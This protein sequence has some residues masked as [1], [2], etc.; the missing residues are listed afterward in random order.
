[1]TGQEAVF[2]LEAL[3]PPGGLYSS[4][5]HASPKNRDPAIA[6]VDTRSIAGIPPH[7]RADRQ[8]HACVR[9]RFEDPCHV[10]LFS[11]EF[12]SALLAIIIIDL[13]L[14]GDN[15]IVIALAARS[16]PP[17]L[18]K[19][20]I[21]WGTVGAIVVRTSMTL[22]VVWLLKVP[23]LLFVGGA[24]LIWIAY[25]LLLPEKAQEEGGGPAV[26]S[27]FWGAIRT[28]VIADTIMGLDNV[29]GVAGAAQ[30]NFT[31][32]VIGLLISI[33]IVVWGST[34]ILKV[35][36]R[37]PALVYLGAGVLAWTAVKMMTIEPMVA[38]YVNA[39]RIIIPALYLLIVGGVLW[40]GFRANH[41]EHETRISSRVKRLPSP[42]VAEVA[43][44][45]GD[46]G[47]GAS[48]RILVP[49]DGSSNA[50]L[51]IGHVIDGFRQNP[52]LEVH[53][54][55]V[56]TPFSSH[57]AQFATK[58]DRDQYH[59]EQSAAA[60]TPLMAMLDQ[61]GIPHQDHYRV[62]PKAQ[63]IADEAERLKC[64]HILI[65]TARRT[66]LTRMFEAS[67]TS[68]LLDLTTVP[69]EVLVGDAVSGIERYGVPLIVGLVLAGLVM[70]GWD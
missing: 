22:I 53:L 8:P 24:L 62:G 63:T 52:A 57:V 18:Q 67:V 68:E 58:K 55:N 5:P 42:A 61:A 41:R 56:Q 54:L 60:M 6:K 36:E 69:V 28:V 16:L 7:L 30:G 34:I 45:V 46:Q 25:K 12:F 59:R 9:N 43:A 66:S 32:V 47:L 31:L 11:P 13:V 44:P 65:V 35:I 70:L 17:H 1:L 48:M 21:L 37:Y 51:A 2:P 49:V 20:A 10:E 33:P 4:A 27:T 38:P 29:L 3:W 15:A 14:A 50:R 19:R 40:F 64:D 26:A 23:G 39:H